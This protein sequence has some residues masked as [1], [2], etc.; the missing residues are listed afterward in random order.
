[1]EDERDRLGRI[2]GGVVGAVAVMAIVAL[3]VKAVRSAANGEWLYA[4]YITA[5]VAM[6]G[7]AV[8]GLRAL[9]ARAARRP[10]AA[11]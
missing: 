7:I 8:W 4:I 5:I 2:L 1:M 3:V 6:F 11:G 10:A 9:D